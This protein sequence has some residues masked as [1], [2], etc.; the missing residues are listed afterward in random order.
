MEATC[1][2]TRPGC[3]LP[4][5]RIR[6][7]RHLGVLRVTLPEAHADAII[8]EL[9]VHK[10]KV[11]AAVAVMEKLNRDVLSRSISQLAIKPHVQAVAGTAYERARELLYAI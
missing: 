7:A 6:L 4:P 8:G 5:H 1:T 3:R 2:R 11:A 10:D 9:R